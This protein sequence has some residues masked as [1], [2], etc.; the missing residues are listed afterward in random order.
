[1]W[2]NLYREKNMNNQSFSKIQLLPVISI[3]IVI[4]VSGGI[5][6]YLKH[7][8]GIEE[9][10]EIKQIEQP[11]VKAPENKTVEEEPKETLI[12]WQVLQRKD[13]GFSIKIPPGYSKVRNNKFE[14]EKGASLLFLFQ[15]ETR[16][17]DIIIEADRKWNEVLKSGYSQLVA[18]SETL[19]G[20]KIENNPDFLFKVPSI[21]NPGQEEFTTFPLTPGIEFVSA[22]K[23][24]KKHCL[25]F[26]PTVTRQE[27]GMYMK[28][29]HVFPYYN[30][31]WGF[32]GIFKYQKENDSLIDE[33]ISTIE[34][35][36]I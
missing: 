30:D 9:I 33:M 16:P 12:N 2:Y 27:E 17:I 34:C 24:E 4:I 1:M 7:W 28:E 36:P 32:N 20:K 11:Q 23:I 26:S 15:A 29:M 18:K 13:L 14:N 21:E 10:P 19:K 25:I 3:L 8:I 35:Q 22:K 6:L 5:F 31:A